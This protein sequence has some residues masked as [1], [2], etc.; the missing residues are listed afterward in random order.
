MSTSSELKSYLFLLSRH[1]CS[2][3]RIDTIKAFRTLKE[4]M[5]AKNMTSYFLH[6]LYFLCFL[7]AV[8]KTNN[9]EKLSGKAIFLVY[10]AP[11]VAYQPLTEIFK[12]MNQCESR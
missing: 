1:Y 12:A 5:S 7:L 10:F 9:A 4:V 11:R 8:F 6:S 2:N 3:D